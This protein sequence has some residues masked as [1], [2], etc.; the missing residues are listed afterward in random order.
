VSLRTRWTGATWQAVPAAGAGASFC[1][2]TAAP[3]GEVWAVGGQDNGTLA[4]RWTG[5]ACARVS[6][7]AGNS[8]KANGTLTG[9]ASQVAQRLDNKVLWL[10]RLATRTPEPEPA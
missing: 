10:R 7:P 3:G 8:T 4:M 5:S 6:I 2:V 1:G 9:A